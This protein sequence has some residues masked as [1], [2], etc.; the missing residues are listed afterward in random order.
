[1][2]DAQWKPYWSD[3]LVLYGLGWLGTY[4][5]IEAFDEFRRPFEKTFVGWGDGEIDGI[6]G[7]SADCKAGDGDYA[8]LHGWKM[9]TGFHAKPFLGIEQTGKRVFMRECDWWRC[10]NEK[11]GE[12]WCMLD[13]LH[14]ALQLGRDIISEI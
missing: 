1:M 14:I 13:T 9:I 3:N 5:K 11:I 6:T 2:K 10:S 7:V 12:S 8:F 4:S